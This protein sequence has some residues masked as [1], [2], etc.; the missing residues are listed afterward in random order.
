MRGAYARWAAICWGAMAIAASAQANQC[1]IVLPGITY[2]S[3]GG[4]QASFISEQIYPNLVG[5][6]HLRSDPLIVSH[7]IARPT[8]VA[9]QDIQIAM[10]LVLDEMQRS[11][12]ER[13][14]SLSEA[15]ERTFNTPN[16]DTAYHVSFLGHHADGH[17]MAAVLATVIPLDGTALMVLTSDERAD[18]VNPDLIALHA[19]SLSNLRLGA[20]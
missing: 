13:F 10:N 19:Q 12:L 8:D 14:A 9:I 7:L 6:Y 18:T 17:V 20:R 1:D 5:N 16:L 11:G 3:D 4:P 15:H 2:C